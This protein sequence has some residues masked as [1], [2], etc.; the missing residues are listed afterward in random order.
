MKFLKKNLQGKKILP[1]Q[2]HE[3]L[4]LLCPEF[5]HSL[6]EMNFCFEL[7]GLYFINSGSALLVFSVNLLLE[8]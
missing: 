3:L 5:V 7:V 8:N 1:M 6:L 2:W 4:N